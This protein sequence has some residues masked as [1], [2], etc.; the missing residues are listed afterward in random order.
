MLLR[1]FHLAEKQHTGR[2]QMMGLSYWMK[3]D[4]SARA[5]F[6]RLL[7]EQVSAAHSPLLLFLSS[8]HPQLPLTLA[9]GHP[10]T[11]PSTTYHG[12]SFSALI[13]GCL[14]VI[15][16]PV[17][18]PLPA[19]CRMIVHLDFNQH[20]ALVPQTGAAYTSLPIVT[21]HR[22]H[23]QRGTVALLPATAECRRLPSPSRPTS[24]FGTTT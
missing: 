6:S 11:P 14:P 4:L 23:H 24:P 18:T 9:T 5:L 2:V 13:R 15:L 7:L 17:A 16:A 20:L 19:F 12:P 10:H 3:R 1:C 22:H 8:P 21:P